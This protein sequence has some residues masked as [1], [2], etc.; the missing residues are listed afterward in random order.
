MRAKKW[1][2]NESDQQ[3]EVEFLPLQLLLSRSCQLGQQQELAVSEPETVYLGTILSLAV[4]FTPNSM[5]S[6]SSAS[7]V[8]LCFSQACENSS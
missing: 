4:N 2:E 8:K 7:H 3:N 6:S 5:P 1:P